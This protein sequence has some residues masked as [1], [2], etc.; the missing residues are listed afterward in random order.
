MA[1]DHYKT[2]GVSKEATDTEIKTAYKKLAKKYH[3]DINKE[4]GAE[5]KFKEINEAYESIST[6]EKRQQSNYGSGFGSSYGGFGSNSG[7]S[8]FQSDNL[9]DFFSDMFNFGGQTSGSRGSAGGSKKGRD[10][11]LIFTIS[12]EDAFYG[13][14]NKEFSISTYISCVQCSGAGGTGGKIKCRDC[15]GSGV[16]SVSNGFISFSN[17][18]GSCEGSGINIA[19]KCKKCNGDGRINAEKKVSIK[20][21]KGVDSNMNLRYEGKGESGVQEGK[22]GDLLVTIQIKPNALFIRKKQDLFIEKIFTLKDLICGG[23]IEII[24]ID[25]KP[26]FVT[27]PENSL[28]EKQIIVKGSGMPKING[29]R[30]NL[31]IEIKPQKQK[32]NNEFIKEFEILYNKYNK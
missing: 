22:A 21:P 30:G 7:F 13:I 9:G 12:L 17:T 20:I 28:N 2:L 24:G 27:I 31:V 19:N 8:G 18:C 29:D 1:K 11:Q 4:P 25:N 16:K 6:A 32:F 14:E 26:V 3:P 10:I 5:N 23:E 15:N